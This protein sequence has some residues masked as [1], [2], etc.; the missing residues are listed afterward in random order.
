M[1][2][3]SPAHPTIFWP[4]QLL[5]LIEQAPSTADLATPEQLALVQQMADGLLEH[6]PEASAIEALEKKMADHRP[7]YPLAAHLAIKLARS[8]QA[9]ESL[10]TPLH[11]SV[12]FAIYKEHTRIL[13]REEHPHGENFLR[14]KIDQLNWLCQG[15]AGVTWE[16][17]LVDDGCPEGSGEL[18]QKILLEKQD[19]E[20]VRVLFLAEAIRMGLPVT[21]PMVTTDDSRKGGSIAYGL[22]EA[23]REPKPN[24][25]VI[26]TDADLSTHLGQCGL[27]AE[28]I[29]KQ[30]ADA[31]IG[32][33]R[34]PLSIV[35][36]GGSRNERG[37]LFIYLWK[38]ML[39]NLA[40]I[41]DTQCGF[42]GFRA[43]VARKI[44][45]GLTEKKFAFDI[46]LL[47]KVQ[48]NRPG[49]IVKIPVAWIDSEAAST[50][51]EFQPY[52]K[53]LKS[54]TGFYRTYLPPTPHAEPYAEL[55]E[56]MDSEGWKRLLD[57]VPEGIV[58]REPIA[59]KD[60]HGVSAQMLAR[61]AGVNLSG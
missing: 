52:L 23:T 10:E 37:K 1:T 18:A 29:V 15:L 33:R 12:I 30:G 32:S 11:L 34:E 45:Q 55:I 8:R 50:T 60:Y 39:P 24:Q 59:F 14:T 57:P 31:A 28:G 38:R 3:H 53:M 21:D 61:I 41:I 4:S 7:D 47:L 51:T 17:V 44:V 43:D 25:V 2:I 16:M 13:T 27:I 40:E 19:Q 58:Q 22:W 56:Q 5:P 42:K 46:E 48:L 35:V 54:I 36:K 6:R 26:Y 9:L 49:A 20:N